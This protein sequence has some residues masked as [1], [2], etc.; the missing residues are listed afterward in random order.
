MPFVP[1]V[2]SATEAGIEAQIAAISGI[3]D[4]TLRWIM[5]IFMGGYRT[6]ARE[7]AQKVMHTIANMAGLPDKLVPLELQKR[8]N[9]MAY[10]VLEEIVVLEV[11]TPPSPVPKTE[12]APTTS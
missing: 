12:D 4:E 2:P 3:T 10:E 6:S 9:D 8:I 1:Y 11:A 7:A 5:T